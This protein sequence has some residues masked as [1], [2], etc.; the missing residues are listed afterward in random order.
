MTAD[1]ESILRSHGS[2][3]TGPRR[4]VWSVLTKTDEHLTVEQITGR[5]HQHDRS[6]NAASV[7]RA[8]GLFNELGLV[9]E[10]K[11]GEGGTTHWELAHPDEHFHIVCNQCGQVDH[12]VGSLVSSIVDHLS[13]D[14]GFEPQQVELT[15]RGICSTCQAH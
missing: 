12:H 8:L 3:S 1:I 5:V 9:R 6:I 10:S 13:G 14:H 11:L 4:A 2:R 7:Y 15:V